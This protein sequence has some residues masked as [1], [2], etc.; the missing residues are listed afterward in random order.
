MPK[1]TKA[2]REAIETTGHGLLVSAAAG[3]GKTS[4]LAAR[5]ASLVGR[6]KN[7]VPL[8][9]LLVVTFTE[10][11]AAEMRDR[12]ARSLREAL[13]QRPAD[14]QLAA[15]LAQLGSADISTIHAFCMRLLR[16]HFVAARLDPTARVLDADEASL[17]RRE[18]LEA[19]AAGLYGRDDELAAGFRALVDAYGTGRDERVLDSL[20]AAHDFLQSIQDPAGWLTAAVERVAPVEDAI[21]DELGGWLLA[22]L[23]RRLGDL[24]E[25][26]RGELAYARRKG[27]EGTFHHNR[28]VAFG[29][30]VREWLDAL[31]AA[32]DPVAVDA[33]IAAIGDY[34]FPSGRGAP[35]KE[36]GPGVEAA[37]GLATAWRDEFKR[38]RRQWGLFTLADW[39]DTLRRTV[40]HIRTIAELLR[41][42]GQRYHRTKAAANVIDFADLE[43]MACDLLADDAVAEAVRGRYDHVLVDEVQDISPIQE[44][45]LTRVARAGEQNLFVVG[46]VKQSIY[47]F[48][49]AEPNLFVDRQ[50]RW[51]AGVTEHA[52]RVEPGADGRRPSDGEAKGP[53][54]TRPTLCEAAGGKCIYLQ[55]NFRS[56]GE[57]LDGVNAIFERL[58]T[59]PFGRIG[60]HEHA[61]LVAGLE[62][63]PAADEPPIELHLID[64]AADADDVDDDAGDQSPDQPWRER[65]DRVERE[66]QCVGL[67]LRTLMGLDGGERLTVSVAGED[68]LTQRP[69]EYRD[70]AVLLR[71]MTGKAPV[72]ARVLSQMGIPVHSDAGGGYLASTEVRDLMAVLELL[73]NAQQDIP[74]ATVLRGPLFGGISE[75]DLA[76]IRL[77][78]R[79]VPFWQ[80]ARAYAE[81]RPRVEEKNDAEAHR[82]SAAAGRT[83]TERPSGPLSPLAPSGVEGWERV[84][85]RAV[86]GRRRSPH[87]IPL[88][89]E[90]GTREDAAGREHH[91]QND[92]VAGLQ[93]RDH[94]AAVGC[95]RWPAPPRPLRL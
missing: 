43:R 95:N 65:L 80:A 27:S 90:A 20:L 69:L 12:I 60:Y 51:S 53:G 41:R 49:L 76:R 11:A 75:D 77:A 14:V 61:K 42:F 59:E 3:A 34:E 93:C 64:A 25:S 68:G 16:Q 84:G 9:R 30:S 15:Q 52:G 74:T 39:T 66:A 4:V 58:M 28:L 63:Y 10:A 88:P 13:A 79:G 92:D 22:G 1:W 33:I 86:F 6:A 37:K 83:Q 89:K 29:R 78:D 87:P 35:K 18:T 73:D 72:Y 81:G 62:G 54:G 38:L 7:P 85:V 21:G 2:Q 17:L 26:C 24:L 19:M 23:R 67:R 8:E 44:A 5:V 32:W 48:R 36:S 45:I 70:I 91:R 40:P 56:R 55:E 82:P 94:S 46:D 50:R 47:R 71:A 57:L 31:P